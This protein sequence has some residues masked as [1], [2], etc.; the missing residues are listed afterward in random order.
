MSFLHAI[1]KAECYYEI[2]ESLVIVNEQQ[3]TILADCIIYCYK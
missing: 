3:V 2:M 1:T